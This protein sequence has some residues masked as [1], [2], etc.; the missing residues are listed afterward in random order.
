MERDKTYNTL[1][2][3]RL[4]TI[5]MRQHSETHIEKKTLELR[6]NEIKTRITRM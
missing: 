5:S 2:N 4:A 1:Q 6:Y 3:T